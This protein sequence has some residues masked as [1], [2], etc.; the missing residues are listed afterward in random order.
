MDSGG[1]HSPMVCGSE[2]LDGYPAPSRG[3]GAES[4]GAGS[5]TASVGPARKIDRRSPTPEN[6][7]AIRASWWPVHGFARILIECCSRAI[8]KVT[9]LPQY[10]GQPVTIRSARGLVRPGTRSAGAVCRAADC[11]L[12]GHLSASTR[13]LILAQWS[14]SI[15]HMHCPLPPRWPWRSA[16]SAFCFSRCEALPVK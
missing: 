14:G 8:S 3:L 6:A 1:S 15:G 5:R 16:L 13:S 10:R 12:V 7:I 2:G 9:L 4:N 11:F